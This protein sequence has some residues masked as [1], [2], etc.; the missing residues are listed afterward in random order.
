MSTTQPI[1]QPNSRIIW[2]RRRCG[3]TAIQ[4]YNA[5]FYIAL[6]VGEFV[7]F[8]VCVCVSSAEECRRDIVVV[9]LYVFRNKITTQLSSISTISLV[10]VLRE[11]LC[12][13]D[14]C[15]KMF[16]VAQHVDAKPVRSVQQTANYKTAILYK[17]NT[18]YSFEWISLHS[19]WLGKHSIFVVG[20]GRIY[21]RWNR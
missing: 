6:L 15:C 14:L 2:S 11:C 12:V 4:C 7:R 8:N 13:A 21:M 19:T 18:I 10:V 17:Y 3:Q 1:E 20:I 9:C 16:C 5:P